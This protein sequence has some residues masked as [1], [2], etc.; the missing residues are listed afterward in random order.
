MRISISGSA[1]SGK[2]TLV[3]AFL[4]KWPMYS[5]PTK[6]Y[7][8]IIK[9][10]NLTHSSNTS[11]ETQL[12]ILDWMMQEQ[13]KYPSGSKVI[14][15]RCPLDNLA[16]TLHGNALGKISDETTAATISFVKE[17]MKDL[18][19]IFWIKHNPNIKIVNDGLRDTSEDYIK[20]TDQIFQGLFDQ[21]MENLEYDVF[22]PKD[23]CPAFICIDNQFVTIDDRL[24]FIGEFIDYKGE[25]IEGDS[26]LDP[27]NLEF[28]E[29]MLKDQEREVENEERINKIVKEFKK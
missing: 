11:D 24:M 16:Y 19:I 2:S 10:N 15:D 3:K 26:I 27:D 14:Y 18:D 6:T 28:L 7:R 22:F 8:D 23:D 21:Y 25:L 1:N 4:N 20:Q 13:S 12:L 9:E 29:N 5:T 17:A